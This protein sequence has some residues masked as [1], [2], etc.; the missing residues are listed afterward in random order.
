MRKSS[1][2]VRLA[3]AT[4]LCAAA[5]SLTGCLS[6]EDSQHAEFLHNPT[7]TLDTY[8]ES[9][10]EMNN[11]TATVLDT[12]YRLLNEELSR[13]FLLERPRRGGYPIPY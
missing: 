5:F 3:L 4:G 1:S 12:N 13:F 6:G 2:V 11:R 8:A 10:A 7:P 9:R